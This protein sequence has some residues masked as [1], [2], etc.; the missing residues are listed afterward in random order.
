MEQNSGEDKHFFSFIL[1]KVFAVN[2][3]RNKSIKNQRN[4][5]LQL[6]TINDKLW[7]YENQ[8]DNWWLALATLKYKN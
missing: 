1:D 2:N 6:K 5:G 7:E 4:K 8:I 3:K